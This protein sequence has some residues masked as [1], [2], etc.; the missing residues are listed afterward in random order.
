MRLKIAL[1]CA[2]LVPFGTA[3][4]DVVT[5]IN[6]AS[7]TTKAS[8]T[9]LCIKLVTTGAGAFQLGTLTLSGIS[10]ND[11]IT[12]NLGNE[13]GTTINGITGT[14]TSS[15]GVFAFNNA[16]LFGAGTFWLF[17]N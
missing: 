13:Y 5:L 4:A 10:S 12:Y 17:I 3:K 1:L 9:N 2:L 8:N 11:T 16:N 6:S 7:G 15:I 14:V